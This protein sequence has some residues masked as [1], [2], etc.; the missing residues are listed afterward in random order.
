MKLTNAKFIA[1]L[2]NCATEGHVLK[3]IEANSS[4]IAE[5]LAPV[6]EPRT[7][8]SDLINMFRKRKCVISQTVATLLLSKLR[9]HRVS[10]KKRE[11]MIH[12][13]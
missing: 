8:A 11:A 3:Y 13:H 9:N 10:Q 5:L 1:N 7:T 4:K 12:V 6:T 2:K